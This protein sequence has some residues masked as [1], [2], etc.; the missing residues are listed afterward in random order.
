MNLCERL[1]KENV[2]YRLELGGDAVVDH[3]LSLERLREAKRAIILRRKDF[4][5]ADARVL[6]QLD[7][8]RCFEEAEKALQGLSAAVQL[9][10]PGNVRLFPRSKPGGAVIHVVNWDYDAEKDSVRTIPDVGVKL[11]LQALGVKGATTA[12]WLV[13]GQEPRVLAIN[14]EKIVIPELPTWGVLELKKVSK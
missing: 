9:D 3:P 2:S 12:R 14:G 7:P 10:R 8:Q 11:N 4:T 6:T 13:P 5:E 1:S